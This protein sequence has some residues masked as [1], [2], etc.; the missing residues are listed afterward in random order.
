[1]ILYPAIDLMN[2]EAV[3][4][5]KG[6]RASVTFYGDPRAIARRYREQGARWLHLVDLDAAFDGASRSLPLIAGI[7]EAFGEPV[8]LGGG[9]RSMADIEARLALGVRRCIIGTAAFSQPDLVAEACARWPGQIAVGID[10][11]NGM[12]AVKGWVETT[13]M[14]AV[15]LALRVKEA[16][17]RTVIYTDISRDGMMSGPNVEA[18]A[19]LREA[20]G[21]EIIASGGVSSLEDIRRLLAAQCEGAIL[22]KALLEGAFTL[23]EALA[24]TEK[25]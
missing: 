20:T 14:T 10:A 13:E 25:A 23:P 15:D 11:K 22:G 9:L 8:E 24:V 6:E 3:R 4:L 16:G 7:V 5:R 2:G 12:A 19:R 17:V 21:L 1:M 18:T